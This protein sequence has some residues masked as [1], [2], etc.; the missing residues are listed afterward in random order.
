MTSITEAQAIH[1]RLAERKKEEK[2]S[3]HEEFTLEQQNKIRGR[4]NKPFLV[5]YRYW[6]EG[7]SKDNI[8]HFSHGIGDDNPLYTNAEYGKN[9][10]YGG[11]IAPTGTP[12]SDLD[13]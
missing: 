6:N 11:L 9:T 2:A 3:G 13:L 4:C 7:A 10:K 5:D 1:P 12:S 8:I